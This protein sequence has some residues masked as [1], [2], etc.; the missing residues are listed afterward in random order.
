VTHDFQTMP[1]HFG[2][3]LEA[4]GS[5]P[6]V[7]FVKLR[8]PLAQVIEAL[9]LVWVASDPEEWKNRILEMPFG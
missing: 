2:G 7:F 9:V 6:G 4:R 8:T 5:S 3:F 1:R